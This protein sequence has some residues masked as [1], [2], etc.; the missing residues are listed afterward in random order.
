MR[1]RRGFGGA[2]LLAG[3]VL[4]LALP[5]TGDWVRVRE[6]PTDL[7][8]TW[9]FA[10]G[11]PPNGVAGVRE[12]PFRSVAVPGSWQEAGIRSHGVAWYRLTLEIAPSLANVPLALTCEQ[13]RDADEVYFDGVLVG[14]TGRFP[15]AYDKATLMS[16]VYVL[17]SGAAGGPGTHELLIRVYNAGPR[18]GGITGRIAL[19][20]VHSAFVG[21]ARRELPRL[22]LAAAIGAL[23]LFSVFVFLRDRSQTGFLTFFLFTSGFALYIGTWNSA[24]VESGVPLTLLFRLN[25]ALALGLFA[26]F[27]LFF[28]R[29]FDRPLRPR[30][31]VVIALQA[32]GFLFGLLWPRVDDLYY[33]LPVGYATIL[34]GSVDVFFTLLADARRGLPYA[35][36]FLAGC[37]LVFSCVIFDIGQDLGAWGDPVGNQR[38]VGFGFFLFSLMVLSLAADRIAKLRTAARSDPLTG[39]ANRAVLFERLVLEL[40]RSR[41]AREPFTAAVL[42]LDHFKRFNDRFGHLAGDRLLAA[43]AG[44]MREATRDTDLV[45]R[46][47]G[48]EFVLLLPA[49]GREEALVCLERVRVAVSAIRLAGVPEGTTAS[50]G[51]A[52]YDPTGSPASFSSTSFL[53]QA[54][55]ALYQAK[56]RGRDRI[57]VAEGAPERGGSSGVFSQELHPP[58]WKR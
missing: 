38:S 35:R 39:L 49:T 28:L 43:A 1:A 24:W 14:R 25:V 16:R 45:A 54:D 19:D 36:P 30:H 7:S 22:I 9:E 48:E 2:A 46:F 23:G 27:L 6:V 50:I 52:L 17:P 32:A 13:I 12:L 15:P 51:V 8:G 33:A 26:L 53:R 56:R 42:D 41:R 31:K 21:R 55:G 11:D 18:A 40:S 20:T 5:A 29:F 47:G 37:C 58:P 57:V 44:A 34:F 4:F 10:P 3:L